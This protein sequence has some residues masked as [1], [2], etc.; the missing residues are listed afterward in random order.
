MVITHHQQNIDDIVW[1][2]GTAGLLS[3]QRALSGEHLDLSRMFCCW[4]LMPRVASS[5]G[6]VKINGQHLHSAC[7]LIDTNVSHLLNSYSLLNL[8]KGSDSGP[9]INLS[10]PINA[11]PE[12]TLKF[13][14]PREYF[15]WHSIVQDFYTGAADVWLSPFC[16]SKVLASEAMFLMELQ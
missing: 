15:W 6:V 5:G 9:G 13:V 1:C 10:S 7:F 3:V 8:D 2:K 16:L 12:G 14:S 11:I 4:P